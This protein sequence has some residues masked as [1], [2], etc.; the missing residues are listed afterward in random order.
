MSCKNEIILHLPIV[1][2]YEKSCL[3][4]QLSIIVRNEY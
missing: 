4:R 2:Y 1:D 3:K